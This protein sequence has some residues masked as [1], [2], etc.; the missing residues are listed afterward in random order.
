MAIVDVYDAL[1]NNR[2]Y[3]GI[4]PHR[5]VV[6]IIKSL[7]GTHFDPDLVEIFLDHEKEFERFRFI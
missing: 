6:D 5:E 3:R 7:S 1:I 4:I 2:P